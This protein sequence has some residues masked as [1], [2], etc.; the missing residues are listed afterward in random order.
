MAHV[1]R[2][3]IPTST[4]LQANTCGQS[5]WCPGKWLNE[6][7][8]NLFFL[9]GTVSKHS[10]IWKM[11]ENLS[12]TSDNCTMAQRESSVAWNELTWGLAT[13]KFNKSASGFG[14]WT[15]WR[16]R[17][18]V[19]FTDPCQHLTFWILMETLLTMLAFFPGC[20]NLQRK[21]LIWTFLNHLTAGTTFRLK[22]KQD[23]WLNDAWKQK[24]TTHWCFSKELR[25]SQASNAPSDNN[26]FGQ[27]LHTPFPK[28]PLPHP[29]NAQQQLP[30]HASKP[31]ELDLGPDQGNPRFSQGPLGPSFTKC[32]SLKHSGF[33]RILFLQ[34]TVIFHL[35]DGFHGSRLEFLPVSAE[36]PLPPGPAW[37]FVLVLCS[38]S[39]TE[40]VRRGFAL[41]RVDGRADG[42]PW[43]LRFSWNSLAMSSQAAIKP[44]KSWTGWGVKPMFLFGLGFIQVRSTLNQWVWI[45]FSFRL[46]VWVPSLPSV[47][48]CLCDLWPRPR[49]RVFEAQRKHQPSLAH[50]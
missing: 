6:S 29:S 18:E 28:G 34:C 8:Q 26:S 3:L 7:K 4:F 30:H 24:I 23:Q 27:F 19:P 35:F 22:N 38:F 14:F 40:M 25:P 46:F 32:P 12:Q 41:G 15:H 49:I 48:A 5:G 50:S 39:S 11:L 9:E 21:K 16:G 37:N 13:Q 44:S 42:G 2:S 33:G 45:S 47:F 43:F 20:C 1:V 31:G 10:Q 17:H 36:S